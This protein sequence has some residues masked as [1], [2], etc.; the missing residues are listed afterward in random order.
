MKVKHWIAFIGLALAWGSSFFW[1]KLALQEIRPYS[2]VALRL[3][4]GLIGMFGGLLIRRPKLPQSRREWFVLGLLGLT[5]TAI[6]FS[7]IAWSLKFIDSTVVSI[8]VSS[9]PIFTVILAHFFIQEERLVARKFLGI[10]VG[11]FGV[12][13][14]FWR[15]IVHIGGIGLVGQLLVLGATSLY[16][17]SAII[18]KRETSKLDPLI[19]SF[20]SI[21]VADLFM[22]LVV[23][24][25]EPTF[26]VPTQMVT[27]GALVWLGIIG[28][29]LAYHL[30]FY[31]IGN[32]GP[33]R[34]SLI[35]YLMPVVGLSLG[36]L[37]LGEDFDLQLVFG[38]ILVLVS[39][40]VVNRVG[41]SSKDRKQHQELGS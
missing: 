7:M 39:I 15:G 22:W 38:G 35:T 12:V 27:W 13:V 3:L 34:T 18:V 4:L 14:L 40:W 31:L 11:F 20:F 32:I 8:L 5:N 17:V 9:T 25:A 37:L 26:I 33:T 30:F 36:V 10:L 29:A 16:A 2:L 6:P 21:L 19:Q 1:N 41:K 28:S 23:L 24:F